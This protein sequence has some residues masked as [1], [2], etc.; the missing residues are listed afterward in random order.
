MDPY[1]NRPLFTSASAKSTTTVAT[2]IK[3][4]MPTTNQTAGLTSSSIPLK[5]LKCQRT[6]LCSV[7]NSSKAA[8]NHHLVLN[9][10]HITTALAKTATV[11]PTDLPQPGSSWS[12][13]IAAPTHNM[14]RTIVPRLL[15]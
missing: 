8:Q 14:T 15:N 9:W 13:V 6:A 2:H 10:G 7:H 12:A 1:Y 11:V 3:S 5:V 4:S